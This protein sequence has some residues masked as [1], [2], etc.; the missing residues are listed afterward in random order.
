MNTLT[1]SSDLVSNQHGAQQSALLKLPFELRIAIYK[2]ALITESG[3]NVNKSIT[4]TVSRRAPHS[5][6]RLNI[7]KV[8]STSKEHLALIKTCA[9]IKDELVHNIT[10]KIVWHFESTDVLTCFLGVNR[11]FSRPT[12]YTETRL[13]MLIGA[14]GVEVLIPKWGSWDDAPVQLRRIAAQLHRP[15]SLKCIDELEKGV[16][17]RGLIA[18]EDCWKAVMEKF[19]DKSTVQDEG[20]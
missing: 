5:N 17:S 2:L 10:K 12:A 11:E 9:Q 18:A 6:N 4:F 1:A 13:K 15:L 3:E 8:N 20:N 14:Q 16:K 19:E 7:Y